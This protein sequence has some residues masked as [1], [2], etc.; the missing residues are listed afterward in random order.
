M[1][2]KK[3]V[4]FLDYAPNSS[5][6]A[7]MIIIRKVKEPH[8]CWGNM[9]PYPVE[10]EG[11]EYRTTEAL[12]QTLRFDDEEIKEAI[13]ENKSP[14]GAKFISRGNRD[15]MVVEP[16]SEKDLNNMRMCLRLKIEQHPKL[17][18]ELLGT[19]DE[20]I[21]EDCT[22]RQRGSGLLWGAA[23]QEDGTW[24]GQ[25]WLG[26]LWMELRDELQN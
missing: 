26:K 24:E 3:F 18:D 22:K 7:N 11:K 25:N 15:K 16:V 14:M 20:E 4:N 6:N 19:G 17:V 21:V 5:Y 8:G 13:R 12:F 10:Y 2:R 1:F 23:Q 9:A